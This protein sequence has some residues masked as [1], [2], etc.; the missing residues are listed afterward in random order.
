MLP[1][2]LMKRRENVASCSREKVVL[3]PFHCLREMSLPELDKADLVRRF[4][5][6]SYISL[7]PIKQQLYKKSSS[8]F[9]ANYWF[10][11]LSF[12]GGINESI[13][14]RA[15]A[16]K[17]DMKTCMIIIK[18]GRIG[19]ITKF[20]YAIKALKLSNPILCSYRLFV[21]IMHRQL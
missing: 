18:I 13:K 14:T 17:K 2:S 12:V 19:K 6:R 20:S 11:V 9:K 3:P 8:F 4:P 10:V 15:R 21:I 5:R 7:P 16:G 1:L